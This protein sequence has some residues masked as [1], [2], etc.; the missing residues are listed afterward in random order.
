MISIIIVSQ[1][2][3]NAAQFQLA[4]ANSSYDANAPAEIS[5]TYAGASQQ[6]YLY[7]VDLDNAS[8]TV[9]NNYGYTQYE[10]TLNTPLQTDYDSSTNT[11]TNLLA[12][13]DVG[14]TGAYIRWYSQE[15]TDGGVTWSS[16]QYTDTDVTLSEYGAQGTDSTSFPSTS[17]AIP[18]QGPAVGSA[19]K[20]WVEGYDVNGACLFKAGSESAPY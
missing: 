12:W 10:W 13:G 3:S 5:E 14:E 7:I 16:T 15:S 20:I 6:T 18:A 17:P 9:N 19:F 1:S 4:V 8:Y 11:Y 2:R